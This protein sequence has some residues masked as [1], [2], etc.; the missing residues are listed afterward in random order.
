MMNNKTFG[1]YPVKKNLLLSQQKFG[2]L[3]NNFIESTKFWLKLN[4]INWIE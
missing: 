2:D 1:C 4:W 3:K